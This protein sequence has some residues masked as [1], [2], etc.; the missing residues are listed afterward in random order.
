MDYTREDQGF[1]SLDY[2]VQVQALEG[3]L[4]R[5]QLNDMEFY[6]LSGTNNGT[7]A[8]DQ[9]SDLDIKKFLARIHT[10]HIP[11]GTSIEKTISPLEDVQEAYVCQQSQSQN[12]DT[13]RLPQNEAD[14][15]ILMCDTYR[16]DGGAP[17]NP[18]NNYFNNT[19]GLQDDPR[20]ENLKI[21]E[22]FKHSEFYSL[23]QIQKQ[24]LNDDFLQKNYTS[25]TEMSLDTAAFLLHPSPDP[26]IP[27][28]QPTQAPN[29]HRSPHDSSFKGSEFYELI[30]I[31]KDLLRENID[32]IKTERTLTENN[33]ERFRRCDQLQQDYA[34]GSG[35]LF[36]RETGPEV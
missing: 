17:A 8:N 6:T 34:S 26:Q 15:N 3:D 27:S 24:L 18:N 25:H 31:K 2:N 36:H 10:I 32:L 33:A 7:Q 14:Q 20:F 22:E 16:I 5:V 13:L 1:P 30:Q 12:D 9:E 21:S 19:S 11:T 4:V 35:D 23:V 28:P 29:P